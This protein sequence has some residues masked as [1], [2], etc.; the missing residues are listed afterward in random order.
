[1]AY[2]FTAP[3]SNTFN[4]TIGRVDYRHS[5][6]QTFFGR[7]NVQ[8]DSLLAYPVPRPG[9]AAEHHPRG[10]QL[11][12]AIGWDAVV[13]TNI[14][15]IFRYGFTKIDTATVGTL[16]DRVIFQVR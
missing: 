6:N 8:R 1:M 10:E 14:V 9:P 12:T 7:F 16:A 2:K 5:A 13:S 3:Y 15:N 4:T 11:G